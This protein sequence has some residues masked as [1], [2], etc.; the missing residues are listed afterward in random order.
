MYRNFRCSTSGIRCCY[1]YVFFF[2]IDFIYQF[3]LLVAGI[4]FS[5]AKIAFIHKR[6][7]RRANRAHIN[8]SQ[9]STNPSGMAFQNGPGTQRFGNSDTLPRYGEGYAPQYPQQAY[10]IPRTYNPVC[11]SWRMRLDFL[12]NFMLLRQNFGYPAVG[13]ES[14]DITDVPPSYPGYHMRISERV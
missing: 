11:N 13:G 14:G 1:W 7:T 6:C 9:T 4:F 2:A 8:N 12:V 5:F 3:R 10:G